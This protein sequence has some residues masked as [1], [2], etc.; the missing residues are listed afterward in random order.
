ISGWSPSRSWPFFF[1]THGWADH[2]SYLAAA[3]RRPFRKRSAAERRPRDGAR[4]HGV[5]RDHGFLSLAP[6]RSVDWRNAIG[7]TLSV[8]PDH[9]RRVFRRGRWIESA[10]DRAHDDYFPVR[11]SRGPNVARRAGAPPC[12]A[13]R[14]LRHLHR[15]EF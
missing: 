14:A 11:V 2:S 3:R 15:P 13:G 8:D 7:G 1:S 6:F 5:E 10:P 9:R 4:L 12:H